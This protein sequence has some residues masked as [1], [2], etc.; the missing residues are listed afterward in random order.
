MSD[1]IAS[2][3]AQLWEKMRSPKYRE[4]FVAAHLS[5]NIAAQIT[6]L[7]ESQ[8]QPWTKRTL[9]KETGMAPARISVI[10]NPSY[11]KHTLS[12]LKR[13]AKAFDV[14][15]VVR[16]EA[17]SSLVKWVADL[18]P[19]KMVVASFSRDSLAE[20]VAQP[21]QA[22]PRAAPSIT[23]LPSS[24]LQQQDQFGLGSAAE[25]HDD[26]ER[27]TSIPFAVLQG[28]SQSQFKSQQLPR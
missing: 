24:E 27:A 18:S 15:L 20:P 2:I 11:D 14:A 17:F 21:V 12:T 23:A 4:A 6:T 8:P 9:A 3:R 19:E 25:R 10:E 1:H 26:S 16:F 28:A 13:V 7:R 22:K 5:T